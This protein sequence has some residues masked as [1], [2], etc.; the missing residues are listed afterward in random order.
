M[1]AIG[2]SLEAQ[3]AIAIGGYC[4]VM[5][6]VATIEFWYATAATEGPHTA[7]RPRYLTR[8]ERARP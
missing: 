7:R 3:A 5:V 6:V 4:L 8:E 1:D 2:P